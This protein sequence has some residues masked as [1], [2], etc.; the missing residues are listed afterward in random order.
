[1]EDLF[2]GLVSRGGDGFEHALERFFVGFQVGREAAFV[3]DGGRV[4]VFLQHGF[5]VMEY[6]DAPAQR[7]A[8]SWARR[9]A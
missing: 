3:S 6:L 5:Q 7:F 9:A 4:A 1:M 8:G 2:A